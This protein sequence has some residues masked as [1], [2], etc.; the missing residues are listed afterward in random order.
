MKLKKIL[1]IIADMHI[2]GPQRSLLNLLS[3]I[4]YSKFEVTVKMFKKEGVLLKE[5]PKNVSVIPVEPSELFKS[6]SIKSIKSL[7][8]LLPRLLIKILKFIYIKIFRTDFNI[9]WSIA[10]ILM[11]KDYI[12]YDVAIAYQE[13][14]SIYYLISK[15]NSPIKIGRIPTDYKAANLNKA[16]DFPYFKKLDKIFVVSPEIREIF[17]SVFPEFKP[18]VEIFY[19]IISS[20]FIKERAKHGKGF[21]D[22]FNGVRILTISRLHSTKGI[23]I[24]IHASSI[25]V[26]WGV[27]F[28]WYVIGD[29]NSVYYE[30]LVHKLCLNDKFI[31]IQPTSNPYGYLDQCDIYVQPSLYEGRS[32]AV[33]EAKSLAKPIVLTNFSSAY[34]HIINNKTGLISEITPESLAQNIALLIKNRELQNRFIDNLKNNNL[35]NSNEIEKIYCLLN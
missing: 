29:G 23:D 3:I 30:E 14:I 33:N 26:K 16:I 5:I 15:I 21:N 2:G 13:G 22:S 25:L 10:S 8:Y 11:P 32:N 24:A 34:E 18:K 9:F 19:S 6:I 31:F 27:I 1:F 28:K 20:K 17:I 4:D 35:D 7:F 12:T